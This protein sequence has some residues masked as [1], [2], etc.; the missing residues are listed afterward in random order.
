MTGFTVQASDAALAERVRRWVDAAALAP[1]R[2]IALTLRLVDR[3]WS[4]TDERPHLRQPGLRFHHGA[5]SDAVRIVWHDGLGHALLPAG[6]ADAVTIELTRTAAAEP[7]HWLRPFVLPVLLVLLRRAGWHHV[8]GA[9]ARDPR[10]RGWLIAGNAHAGKS[11]TAAWL[12]T[13]RWAVGTDDTALLA[14]GGTRV[15]AVS[16]REPIALRDG[17]LEL[18]ARARGGT[19]LARRGKT[20]FFPEDLGGTWLPRV[21]VD[22]VALAR[23]HDGPTTVEPVRAAVAVAELLS[24]SLLF[25]VDPADAQRH[26][27]LVAR[28]AQQA[29]CVRLAL[30]RD[31]IERPLALEDLV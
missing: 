18:L 22:V 19:P 13:R 29:T 10:G 15:E 25:M 28:L 23:L 7:D 24:W 14:N 1:P 8:H 27:D 5:P 30:G 21:P 26:L 6:A 12:A 16:W 17:G 9:V 31:L 3:P 2:S 11:T 20:G 4:G